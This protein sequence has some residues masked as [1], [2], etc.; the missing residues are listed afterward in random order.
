MV[1]VTKE[2][3]GAA[4]VL[5]ITSITTRWFAPRSELNAPPSNLYL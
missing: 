3:I 5:G 1:S 4:K 2:S